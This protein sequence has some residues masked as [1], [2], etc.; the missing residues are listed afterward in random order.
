[1]NK[2]PIEQDKGIYILVMN[3]KKETDIAFGEKMAVRFKKGIYLYTGRASGK[4]RARIDRHL[5][6]D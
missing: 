5:R 3:L 6:K 2:S 4:L 1:M